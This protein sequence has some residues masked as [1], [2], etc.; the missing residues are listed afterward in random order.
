MW[1]LKISMLL[2]LYYIAVILVIFLGKLLDKLIVSFQITLSFAKLLNGHGK[3]LF[4]ENA[5][6]LHSLMI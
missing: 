5:L 2:I 4:W 6:F 1:K 3:W